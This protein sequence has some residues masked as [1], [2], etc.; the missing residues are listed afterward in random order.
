MLTRA[1]RK[2]EFD[3]LKK[4]GVKGIKIDRKGRLAGDAAGREHIAA[5]KVDYQNKMAK[6]DAFLSKMRKSGKIYGVPEAHPITT[7]YNTPLVTIQGVW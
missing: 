2:N 4:L 7:S 6:R 5:K 1:S 3:R